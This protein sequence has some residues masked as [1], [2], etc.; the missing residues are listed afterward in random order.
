MVAFPASIPVGHRRLLRPLE[1]GLDHIPVS[2]AFHTATVGEQVIMQPDPGHHVPRLQTAD[3][4]EQEPAL[5]Q[6]LGEWW[7]QVEAGTSD[8][9]APLT[10]EQLRVQL[11]AATAVYGKVSG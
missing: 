8:T 4:A 1:T 10:D 9:T 2:V 3:F 5:R 11:K 7:S 6:A